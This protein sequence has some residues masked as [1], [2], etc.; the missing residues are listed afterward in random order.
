VSNPIVPGKIPM[1]ASVA[2]HVI[3][4]R[5]IALT[6]DPTFHGKPPRFHRGLVH[7][8]E[9]PDQPTAWAITP[10]DAVHLIHLLLKALD[11]MPHPSGN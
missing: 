5:L 9:A 2:I 4:G 8:N 6:F 11:H 7:K 10:Q 1:A 3:D